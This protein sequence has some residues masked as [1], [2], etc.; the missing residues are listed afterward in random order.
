[1]GVR[2]YYIDDHR[3]VVF[4]NEG[5]STII[6]SDL[7]PCQ[8]KDIGDFKDIYK[9]IEVDNMK[10]ITRHIDVPKPFIDGMLEIA[11]IGSTDKCFSTSII[12][13]ISHSINNVSRIEEMI[14]DVISSYERCLQNHK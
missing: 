14:R 12:L 5:E 9:V 8:I 7:Y 11:C 4:I 3:K 13:K 10:I 1:M 6:I 2:D